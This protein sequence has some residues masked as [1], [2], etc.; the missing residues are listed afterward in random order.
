MLALQYFPVKLGV[1][2]IAG[3]SENCGFHLRFRGENSDH[4]K[5][6]TAMNEKKSLKMMF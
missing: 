1:K 4:F 6:T 3:D 2:G 5:T